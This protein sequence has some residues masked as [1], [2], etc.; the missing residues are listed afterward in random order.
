MIYMK[1][2]Q[3]IQLNLKKKFFNI[4]KKLLIFNIKIKFYNKITINY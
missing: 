4:N 3:K 2:K 1:N